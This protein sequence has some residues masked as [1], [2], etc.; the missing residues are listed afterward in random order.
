MDIAGP[1]A[2]LNMEHVNSF[3]RLAFRELERLPY[4]QEQQRAT[5]PR[6]VGYKAST[7]CLIRSIPHVVHRN[8]GPVAPAL[9]GI[10]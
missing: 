1:E 6:D 2:C 3:I 5:T 9:S 7:M 4:I 10:K 8:M